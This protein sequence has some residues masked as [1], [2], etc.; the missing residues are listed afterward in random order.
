MFFSI[1]GLGSK[2][3][4]DSRLEYNYSTQ[5][6]LANSKGAEA[7][8]ATE[9]CNQSET[10]SLTE[11]FSEILSKD[12]T[13]FEKKPQPIVKATKNEKFEPRTKK[14]FLSHL[15][16][17]QQDSGQRRSDFFN[18]RLPLIKTCLESMGITDVR[19]G[20][21]ESSVLYQS[22]QGQFSKELEYSL[23]AFLKILR[24]EINSYFINM[25]PVREWL[26][27]FS[28]PTCTQSEKLTF[29]EKYG[30]EFDIETFR[31]NLHFFDPISN[32]VKTRPYSPSFQQS[33]KAQIASLC[34]EIKNEMFEEII[35]AKGCLPKESTLEDVV[36]LFC[37]ACEL[38]IEIIPLLNA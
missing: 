26:W 14:V 19:P 32:S 34:G 24:L 17:L 28:L 16:T 36:A 18:R 3:G 9:V 1:E 6:T 30:L 10:T 35:N 21:S 29:A 4:V 5:S 15:P 37:S 22:K 31:L 7:S 25:P 2:E 27:P 23:D 12:R 8:D 20:N 13:P 38:K 11:L 33:D